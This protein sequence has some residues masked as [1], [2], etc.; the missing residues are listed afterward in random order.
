MEGTQMYRLLAALAVTITLGLL[1]RLYPV[2]WYVYDKSLGDA[3]YAMAAY[4]VLA[5]VLFRLPPVL[6]ATV[7]LTFCG[8]I[9]VFKLTGIPARLG[10]LTVARWT[11][12]TTFSWHNLVCYVVGIVIVA[13]LD[14]FLLRPYRG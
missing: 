3:L 9:E 11:L 4:L 2:G 6:V 7:A 8:G 12:A 1:S 14:R 5:L 13:L 10:H